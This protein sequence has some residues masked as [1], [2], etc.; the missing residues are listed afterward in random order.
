MFELDLKNTVLR[1]I[2]KFH[3]DRLTTTQVIGITKLKNGVFGYSL[4]TDYCIVSMF[5]LDLKNT[6]L[7]SIL[8]F[9]NDQ[10]T[11]TQVIGITKLQK[12][13]FSIFLVAMQR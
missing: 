2:L 4:A 5:E 13:V 8:K 11:T 1:S 9:Y 10:L 6:V 12:W 3:N 7:R